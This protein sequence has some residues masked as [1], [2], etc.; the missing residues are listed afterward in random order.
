M[1]DFHVHFSFEKMSSSNNQASVPESL[2]LLPPVTIGDLNA[3]IRGLRI[4]TI[5]GEQSLKRKRE[6]GEGEF[7]SVIY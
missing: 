1:L 5:S 4:L 6:K 2:S 3:L 7:F